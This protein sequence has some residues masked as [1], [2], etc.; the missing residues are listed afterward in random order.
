M[1]TE[2]II[3]AKNAIIRPILCLLLD[4]LCSLAFK[5]SATLPEASVTSER[6]GKLTLISFLNLD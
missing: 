6:S 2:Q 4:W 3:S 1:S 5:Q